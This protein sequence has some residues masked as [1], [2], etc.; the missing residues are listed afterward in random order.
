MRE[1]G[2]YALFRG[3]TTDDWAYCQI[4]SDCT[5]RVLA[6]DNTELITDA[7]TLRLA[8]VGGHA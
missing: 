7:L 5:S 3:C 8:P 4:C 1:V 6:G 2:A